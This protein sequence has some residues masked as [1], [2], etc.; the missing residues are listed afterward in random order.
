MRRFVIFT[1]RV[2]V[3]LGLHYLPLRG[4]NFAAIQPRLSQIDLVWITLSVLEMIF[5]ARFAGARFPI[6]AMHP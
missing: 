4:I 3:S 5:P 2:A 6:Y 1:T